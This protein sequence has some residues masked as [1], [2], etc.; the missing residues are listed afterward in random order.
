M[1][2][3]VVCPYD[4]GA[5]GG[6]QRIVADLVGRLRAH[7]DDAYVVAPGVSREM[8]VDVGRSIAVPGN[9][10]NAPIALGPTVNRRV[11]EA[12][13]DC[14]V[15]HVHEPLMPMVSLAALS[16]GK[17]TVATFHAAV[18]PWTA[19]LYRMFDGVGVRLLRDA[20]LTAVSP[21]AMAAL[22]DAWAPVTI[23]PNGI[24]VASF[25]V[26]VPRVPGRIALVGRD[27]PRK[28]IDVMLAAFGA[29]RASFPDTELHVVGAD[30]PAVD[31]V[32]FH[33]RVRDRE[34]REILA[35]SELYVAPHLG[36]ESFGLVLAEAMA[37]GCAVIASDLAA[38]RSVGGEA[39]RYFGV[40]DVGALV[41]EVESLL[42]APPAIEALASAG[43]E[44]VEMFDWGRIIGR[45]RAVYEWVASI[46][47]APGSVPFEVPEGE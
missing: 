15:V 40:S 9:G 3:A 43:A 28:G 18:A 13:A 34:K 12:L 35:S 17:P 2:V 1:R 21:M 44:R 23:I 10:S 39:V 42:G 29:I 47:N 41:R 24:D 33:G 5:F 14:D 31:G 27:E 26:D 6:V 38:F 22:P 11:R 30:R 19:R 32:V 7:G 37:A 16:A 45:Y 8:G 20:A 46:G 4:F 36:G 25:R